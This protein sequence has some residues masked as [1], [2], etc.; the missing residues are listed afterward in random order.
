MEIK[1][2]KRQHLWSEIFPEFAAVGWVTTSY[3]L[4]WREAGPEPKAGDAPVTAHCMKIKYVMSSARN[5]GGGV[6]HLKYFGSGPFFPLT[7]R[8][9]TRKW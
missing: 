6:E 4:W 3:H 8:L 9:R 2:D 5:Q 1:N 7:K